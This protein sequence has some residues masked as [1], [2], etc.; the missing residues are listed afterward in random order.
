MDNLIPDDTNKT[1]EEL[2]KELEKIDRTEK[3]KPFSELL[4]KYGLTEKD[5]K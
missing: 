4:K 3:F 5:L 2:C 1:N